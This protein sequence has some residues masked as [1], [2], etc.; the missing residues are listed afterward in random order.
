[1]TDTGVEPRPAEPAPSHG[2]GPP[3]RDEGRPVLVADDMRFERLFVGRLVRQAGLRPIFAADGREAMEAIRREDP[4]AVLSDMQMPEIGGL[5]LVKMVR[6][7]HPH[8]PV[9]LM[10]ANDSA[11]L[12]VQALRAGAASFVAKQRLTRDL[13]G[14]LRQVLELA[15]ADRKR[16]ELLGRLDRREAAFRL[17]NDQRLFAPLVDLIQADL[18]AVGPWDAPAR[19]Q[20]GVALHEALAN[21]LYH[22]NLEV[23]SE[24]RQSDDERPFYELAERRRHLDP[25]R[26]R[27]IHVESRIDRSSATFRIRDEGPGFDTSRLA[28]PFDPE[29]LARVG[30][31]GLLLIRAFMDE[32]EHSPAGNEIV[33]RKAA[34]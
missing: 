29:D 16:F 9:I 17:G 1:M 22:G 3:G 30:G 27:S 24:L 15:E 18:A 12:A 32:V 21:A 11:E 31:R 28:M 8:I 10:T 14:A 23:D 7:S 5:E 20:V 13:A 6:V 19:M 34:P 33:L 2:A 26:G 25:Y 4:V